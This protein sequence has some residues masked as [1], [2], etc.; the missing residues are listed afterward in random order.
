MG[1]IPGSGRSAGGGNG[2]PLQ[3]S[4]LRNPMERAAWWATVHGVSK[5]LDM[6][7]HAWS[8]GPFKTLSKYSHTQRYWGLGLQLNEFG[9]DTS[10]PVT[11][12]DVR[13]LCTIFAVS[14]SL[15]LFQN[16]KFFFKD[17]TH[18]PQNSMATVV[19]LARSQQASIILGFW[20]Q[21]QDG[22]QVGMTQALP[23]SAVCSLVPSLQV[24]R[25]QMEG[26]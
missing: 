20:G 11:E 6:T 13:I 8:Q 17:D 18:L 26:T 19:C 10:Q 4:C 14:S 24:H 21:C 12:G 2:N 16:N 7:E 15:K 5:E 9:G 23:L 22:C 3:Y 1:S 25:G